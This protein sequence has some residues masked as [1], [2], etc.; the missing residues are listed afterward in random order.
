MPAA[1][2]RSS[3]RLHIHLTARP[4]TDAHRPI[5]VLKERRSLNAFHRPQMLHDLL[6]ILTVSITR[7]EHRLINDGPAI[8]PI[9]FKPSRRHRVRHELRRRK[10]LVRKNPIGN[11]RL[12]RPP[13][14][15]LRRNAQHISRRIRVHKR[16]RI[17]HDGRKNT[18]RNIRRNR[19][20]HR[21]ENAQHTSPGRSLSLKNII[22]KPKLRI[23]QMMV[24]VEHILASNLRQIFPR[25]RKIAHIPKHPKRIFR[26]IRRHR[27]RDKFRIRQ[28][29]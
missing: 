14:H 28:K 26:Q 6:G 10:P 13:L 8:A 3:R 4:Q 15:H 18:R 11:E 21:L 1:T 17:R 19:Y 2:Q 22:Q 25:P 9:F 20:V 12:I 27:T 29:P 23:P 16:T 7:L 5:K 24:D